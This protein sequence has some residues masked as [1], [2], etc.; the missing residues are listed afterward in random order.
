M[1]PNINPMSELANKAEINNLAGLAHAERI[2]RGAAD[3]PLDSEAVRKMLQRLESEDPDAPA[4][5]FLRHA[6]AHRTEATPRTQRHRPGR[7]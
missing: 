3:V 4:I 6:L 5:P 7:S 2:D 1:N